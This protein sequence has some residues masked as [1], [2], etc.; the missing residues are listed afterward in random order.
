[1]GTRVELDQRRMSSAGLSTQRSLAEL[2]PKLRGLV[3]DEG[4]LDELVRQ[5]VGVVALRSRIRSGS[6]SED[7]IDSHAA[8]IERLRASLARLLERGADGSGAAA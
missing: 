5:L 7:E 1:M 6:A 2:A 8:E 4:E 3:A